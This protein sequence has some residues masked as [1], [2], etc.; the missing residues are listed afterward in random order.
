MWKQALIALAI[1]LPSNLQSALIAAHNY[2]VS[3]DKFLIWNTGYAS[4]SYAIL[5][6][7]WSCGVLYL[8]SYVW[9]ACSHEMLRTKFFIT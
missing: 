2:T 4:L 3:C 9:C 5:K 8:H 7:A 6:A 1:L